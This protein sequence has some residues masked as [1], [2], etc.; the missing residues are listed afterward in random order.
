MQLR[1]RINI[2][3]V[4]ALLLVAV[5]IATP[6]LLI[7][8]MQQR[9]LDALLLDD[10]RNTWTTAMDAAAIA[11]L[12]P[13]TN[14]IP[15]QNTIDQNLYGNV[16]IERMDY[17]NNNLQLVSSISTGKVQ[18]DLVNT[19]IMFREVRRSDK[20]VGLALSG[21]LNSKHQIWLVASKARAEGGFITVASKPSVLV[22]FLKNGIDGHFFIVDT[23]GELLASS[24]P[25]LWENVKPFLVGKVG[26]SKESI[27][28]VLYSAAVLPVNDYS[29]YRIGS[30]YVLQNITSSNR[31]EF[32]ILLITGL[33]SFVMLAVLVVAMHSLIGQAMKPLSEVS[34]AVHAIADGDI[35]TPLQMATR[36]DEVGEIAK[37][38]VVFQNHALALAK[39]EFAEQV[40][41]NSTNQL[42]S[43]EIQKITQVLE[44]VEQ[45]A[46]Q[47]DMQHALQAEGG[48]QSSLALTFQ[49]VTARV[50]EQQKRLSNVLAERSADL[51][52][53]R[54]ALDERTQLNRLREEL[55]LASQLQT[56]SLPRAQDANKLQPWLDLFADMR[57]AK[58]VGGDFYDYRMLDDHHLMLVVGD[59]S[60]KGVSAGMFVLMTRTL[61]RAN[62]SIE[63]TPA[64][65]LFE[66][67]NALERDN[68]AM[69]FTTVFLGI[70][71]L[72]TG[73]M[74]YA[75]AGHNP[76]YVFQSDGTVIR[77]DSASGAMLG[78]MPDFEYDNA[79]VK[80]VPKDL[81]WL[82]SDGI[83]EAHNPNQQLF[84]EDG[85]LQELGKQPLANAEILVKN[86]LSKVD[87]FASTA[88]QFDDMT[89][90]ACRFEQTMI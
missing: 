46:L 41:Q 56:S 1:T 47:L 36:N 38:V 78:V 34:H 80:L 30:L 16:A 9:D 60:G 17:F 74:V 21:K 10:Y 32:L 69:V 72:K 23:A 58:E 52:L 31:Q 4:V 37:A 40:D 53:V 50:V 45:Q 89:V 7:N 71:D 49:L 65:S 24:T 12:P 73:V 14:P 5:I 76:P 66:T 6:L 48:E 88:E 25:S 55:A 15:N 27:G 82:Y 20:V 68:Q 28:D 57:P 61:L 51:V 22:S 35:Y 29:G 19:E 42:I 85:M 70:L 3:T 64:Q 33:A 81:L 63:K 79:M 90:L 59:A 84:G 77:L 44:P 87:S 54:K 43:V 39:R 75:N 86:L 2:F 26:V 62:V 83:T 18:G 13:Q 67:N 11:M 8:R